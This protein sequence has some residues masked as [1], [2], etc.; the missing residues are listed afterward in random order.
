MQFA[1]TSTEKFSAPATET[2][3]GT[4]HTAK[5]VLKAQIHAKPTTVVAM[6]T[7][8]ALTTAA[9]LSAHVMQDSQGTVHTA[10]TSMNVIP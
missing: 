6:P 8:L 5:V 9:P 10:L 1:P 3:Q 7:Q 4:A 2:S